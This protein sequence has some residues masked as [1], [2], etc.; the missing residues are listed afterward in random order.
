MRVCVCLRV[1]VEGCQRKLQTHED[2]I[3]DYMGVGMY[4]CV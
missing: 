2:R 1:F 4:E 3:Y